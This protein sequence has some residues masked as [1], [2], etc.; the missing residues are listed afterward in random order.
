MWVS[1]KKMNSILAK[2]LTVLP[3]I[4]FHVQGAVIS[5]FFLQQVWWW[6]DCQVS[7]FTSP[8][9]KSRIFQFINPASSHWTV[10]INK[11]LFI[12]VAQGKQTLNPKSIGG[13][14]KS[15][16]VVAVAVHVLTQ[17]QTNKA[18]QREWIWGD[19][20]GIPEKKRKKKKKTRIMTDKFCSCEFKA[21]ESAN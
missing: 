7:R 16:S 5:L 8:S 17:I 2:T 15:V 6:F 1:A 10:G 21:F 3:E 9:A 20:L 12:E 13:F 14:L 19:F 18:L 4:E 11:L